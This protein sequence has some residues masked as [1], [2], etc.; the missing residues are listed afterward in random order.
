MLSFAFWKHLLGFHKA[1]FIMGKTDY[2]LH[3]IHHK[4][5]F[6]KLIII[7]AELAE[8]RGADT[9]TAHG[10]F[11]FYVDSIFDN[12]GVT[13]KVSLRCLIG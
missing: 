3:K 9:M 13:A 6:S 8:F 12:L 7:L 5:I 11:W 10:L 4:G 2:K 1:I